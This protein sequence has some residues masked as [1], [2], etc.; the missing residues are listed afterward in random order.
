MKKI[1]SYEAK[2]HLPAL[3]REV[4]GGQRFS[5]TRNGHPVAMLI[6]AESTDVS[7]VKVIADIKALRHGIT[8]GDASLKDLIDEGRR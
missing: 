1:G 2:T 7:P 8:L 5:I 4:A 6:P 3:L